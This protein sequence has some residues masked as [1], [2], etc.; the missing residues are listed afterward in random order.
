MVLHMTKK[1][2]LTVTLPNGETDSRTTARTYTH[3]VVASRSIERIRSDFATEIA[4]QEETLE[5]LLDTEANE[6]RMAELA[7]RFES[8]TV[9]QGRADTLRS[10][11]TTEGYLARHAEELAAFEADPQPEWFALTWCGRLDLAEKAL[12]TSQADFFTEARIVE[13]NS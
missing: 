3:A 1:Q 9:E 7:E 8:Y 12:N 4:R 2:T 10:I 13:V 11:E 6:K 5:G